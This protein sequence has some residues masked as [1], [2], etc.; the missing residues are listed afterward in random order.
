[1][2]KGAPVVPPLG[3]EARGPLA[4]ACA[5]ASRLC[6]GFGL[7]WFGSSLAWC[8]PV[9]RFRWLVCGSSLAGCLPVPR[10]GFDFDLDLDFELDLDFD[11]PERIAGPHSTRTLCRGSVQALCG[12]CAGYPVSAG[13][14]A[15]DE[16]P[17]GCCWFWPGLGPDG[18]GSVGTK[19]YHAAG[20]GGLARLYH[21]DWAASPP[22]SSG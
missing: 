12:R 2:G 8:V 4:V 11:L 17:G 21:R 22:P 3:P 14:Q 10:E 1:M 20:A 18:L 13:R 5:G 9:P 7:R 6:H 19:G 15:G 16:C